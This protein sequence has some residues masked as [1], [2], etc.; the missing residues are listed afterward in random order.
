MEKFR[1][2]EGRSNYEPLCVLNIIWKAHLQ[3]ITSVDFIAEHRLI[4]T[5]SKDTSIRAWTLNGKHVGIFGQDEAWDLTDTKTFS[6]CPADVAYIKS[7]ERKIPSKAA[8]MK[9]QTALKHMVIRMMKGGC[10]MH[11]HLF[12]CIVA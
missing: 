2:E 3:A 1:I 9:R 8:I 4:L 7:I 11:I 6:S 10:A 5:S 12:V